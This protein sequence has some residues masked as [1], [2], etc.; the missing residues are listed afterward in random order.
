MI[1]HW[2]LWQLETFDPNALTGQG[3]LWVAWAFVRAMGAQWFVLEYRK[4]KRA[5][6]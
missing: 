4:A 6:G 2:I 3:W 1:G 5:V